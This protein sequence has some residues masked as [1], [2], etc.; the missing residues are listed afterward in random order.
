MV[1]DDPEGPRV[2]I[3]DVALCNVPLMVVG[4]V[5]VMAVPFFVPSN[6]CDCDCCVCLFVGFVVEVRSCGDVDDDDDVDDD[7]ILLP[8]AAADVRL[9]FFFLSCELDFS[10][11]FTALTSE[12]TSELTLTLFPPNVG[13][14][15]DLDGSTDSLGWIWLLLFDVG[16]AVVLAVLEVVVVVVAAA[17]AAV[18][19][20]VVVAEGWIP[21]V[22]DD[23]PT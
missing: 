8:P 5:I 3:S 12:L 7:R 19:V 9:I 15:T 22:K 17:A 10:L 2:F 23:V 4:L 14:G 18:V 21:P 20:V 16:V 6:S 11:P 13:A 1:G